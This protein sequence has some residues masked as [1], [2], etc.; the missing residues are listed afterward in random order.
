MAVTNTVVASHYQVALTLILYVMDMMIV[1]MVVMRKAL[2]MVVCVLHWVSSCTRTC[3]IHVIKFS[4]AFNY[5]IHVCCP[6]HATK[7]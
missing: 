1:Q 4:L 5:C 3:T 6:K 7:Y 2:Q